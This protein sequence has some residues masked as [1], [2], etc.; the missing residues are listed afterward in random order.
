MAMGHSIWFC[1]FI[2][3]CDNMQRSVDTNFSYI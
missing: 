1:A 2:I 3:A